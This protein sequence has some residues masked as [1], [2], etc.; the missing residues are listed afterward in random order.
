MVWDKKIQSILPIMNPT[1]AIHDF[2]FNEWF[3]NHLISPG[4]GSLPIF[5]DVP[6][7]SGTF[8]VL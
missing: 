1:N 3:Q 2:K 8:F 5:G 4:D 6:K 7:N